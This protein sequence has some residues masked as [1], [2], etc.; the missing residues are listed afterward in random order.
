MVCKAETLKKE[1]RQLG[2]EEL[3]AKI[4][5]IYQQRY[6]AFSKTGEPKRVLYG[7]IAEALNKEGII[8]HQEKDWTWQKVHSFVGRH[9]AIEDMA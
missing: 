2:E 1:G 3:E 9:P 6:E 5:E 4:K 7:E 8:T